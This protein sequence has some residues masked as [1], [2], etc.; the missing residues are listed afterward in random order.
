MTCTGGQLERDRGSPG[1]GPSRQGSR[2]DVHALDRPPRASSGLPTSQRFRAGRVRGETASGGFGPGL[3]R[4]THSVN[5][6]LPGSRGQMQR[7]S[8]TSRGSPEGGRWTGRPPLP[9]TLR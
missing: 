6:L 1:P 3:A 5:G 8:G 2:K 4:G 7:A 9:T